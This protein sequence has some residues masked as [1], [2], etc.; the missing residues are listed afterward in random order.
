[1]TDIQ[2]FLVRKFERMRSLSSLRRK[3][4]AMLRFTQVV[5][6]CVDG[7]HLAQ[8]RVSGGFCEHGNEMSIE[9]K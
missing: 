6:K 5:H 3:R 7:I 9:K 4:E 8:A 1:M 2:K